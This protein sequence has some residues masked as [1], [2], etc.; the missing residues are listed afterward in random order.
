MIHGASH[1]NA[2]STWEATY[3]RHELATS[4]SIAQPPLAVVEQR[5]RDA[6]DVWDKVNARG[7]AGVK[8]M[9]QH[10]GDVKAKALLAELRTAEPAAWA[11]VEAALVAYEARFDLESVL[12]DALA[13]P[14]QM[15][16][17]L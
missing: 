2:D 13:A 16:R 11:A 9:R 5:L 3:T 14:V 7:E 12:V 8:Y 6:W 1:K 17:M 10:P 4:L 15:E